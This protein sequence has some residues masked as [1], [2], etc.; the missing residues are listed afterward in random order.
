MK[1]ILLLVALTCFVSLDAT[2]ATLFVLRHADDLDEGRDPLLTET[3]K[4][5]AEELAAMLASAEIEIILSSDYHRTRD[6]VAPLSARIGVEVQLYDPR[7]LPGLVE[8]LKEMDGRVL[9]VG[10][11]NTTPGLVELL[12]GEPGE[13][14]DE[15][16][17][18]RLY[19][20]RTDFEGNAETILLR[21]GN[22]LT[23][24]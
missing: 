14:I 17:F 15:S 16:E 24:P 2:A 19:I 18:D 22:A 6:T 21:Y 12:G 20:V 8:Q 7:D 4:A 10:H 3:G 9:V 11:S 5:R 1:R 13:P 23:T